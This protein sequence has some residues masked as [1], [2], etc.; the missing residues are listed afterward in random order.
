MLKLISSDQGLI[1]KEE[2]NI[3]DFNKSIENWFILKV[4]LDRIY[5]HYKEQRREGNYNIIFDSAH[6][7]ITRKKNLFLLRPVHLEK[8]STL[9]YAGKYPIKIILI[10][11]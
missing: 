6:H 4:K 2:I 1:N 9:W 8:P 3:E 10:N 5:E 7:I 11:I